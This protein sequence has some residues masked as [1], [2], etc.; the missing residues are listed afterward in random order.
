MNDESQLTCHGKGMEGKIRIPYCPAL[1]CLALPSLPSLPCLL[2][3]SLALSML[4]LEF[5]IFETCLA[6]I[7]C[8]GLILLP[9]LELLQIYNYNCNLPIHIFPLLLC[10]SIYILYSSMF[11]RVAMKEGMEEFLWARQN[12]WLTFIWSLIRYEHSSFTAWRLLYLSV[13]LFLSFPML[14]LMLV[15]QHNATTSLLLSCH[16]WFQ[17][18]V[19]P[20]FPISINIFILFFF[21]VS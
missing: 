9:H 1:L 18:Q 15:C 6:R 5:C 14:M 8:S 13:L 16:L 4:V 19:H 11:L 12:V 20:I 7:S 2:L 17:Y 10:I 3:S 21:S